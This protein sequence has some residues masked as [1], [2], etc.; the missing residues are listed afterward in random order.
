MKFL[1]DDKGFSESRVT[2]GIKKIKS[3]MAGGV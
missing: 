1:K 2:N 3:K